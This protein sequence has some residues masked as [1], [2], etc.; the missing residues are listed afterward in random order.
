LA[1]NQ[2]S[3]SSGENKSAKVLKLSAEDVKKLLTPDTRGDARLEVTEKIAANYA[4]DSFD[5]NASLIAEQIFRLLVRDTEVKVRTMMAERL[6]SSTA[7]PRDIVMVMAKDVEDAVALPVL[8]Y[9]EVLA[10]EDLIALVE[11]TKQPSR[12]V[13][14]SSRKEVPEALADTLI[15]TNNPVVALTLAVV[16]SSD[17]WV[18]YEVGRR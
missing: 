6:K 2:P 1:K 16:R 15:K 8:Q 17:S 10:E 14:V 7:L 9:S 13:A 3:T 5:P 11:A 4:G 18:H 12:H